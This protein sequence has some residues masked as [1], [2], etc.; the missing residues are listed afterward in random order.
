MT[1]EYYLSRRKCCKKRRDCILIVLGTY[2]MH[3]IT[4]SEIM[5]QCQALLNPDAI[6]CQA[7]SSHENNH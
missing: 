2:H 5:P 6:R 7:R 4:Q 1:A 3:A